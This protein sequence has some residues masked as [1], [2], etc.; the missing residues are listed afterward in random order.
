[1]TQPQTSSTGR[2]KRPARKPAKKAAPKPAVAKPAPV[3]RRE[4]KKERTRQRIYES[5]MELFG[6][7]GF[8]NVTIEEIC[9]AADIAK[10]T[11]FLHFKT[12]ASLIFES[13]AR[14]TELLRKE[15]AKPS[16]SARKDLERVTHLMIE[17]WG[18]R[19][20]VME[21]MTREVLATPV[22]EIGAQP[23]NAEFIQL[24]VE[25]FRRGQKS[26]ELRK[27]VLP[28]LAALSF[29]ATASSIAAVHAQKMPG[30]DLGPFIDQFLN[31]VFDGLVN[32][33]TRKKKAGR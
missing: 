11:Y 3:S 17:R 20:E 25:I 18:E 2:T 29:F 8:D 13:T 26:G 33:A 30:A 15:L 1:M 23:E 27:D 10:A 5:A 6:E 21:A 14:L 31:M 12:K 22:S 9:E 7:R 24:Y 19:R 16:K 28:E 32:P 4:R